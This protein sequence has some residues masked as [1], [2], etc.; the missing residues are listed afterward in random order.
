MSGRYVR[1]ALIVVVVLA[2]AATGA[3]AQSVDWVKQAGGRDIDQ[4]RGVGVDAA[5]NVYVTGVFGKSLACFFCGLPATFGPGSPNET[6]LTP[7]DGTQ[8]LFVAKYDNAGVLQWAKSAGSGGVDDAYGIAV[9]HEGNSYVTCT[10]GGAF[11]HKYDTNGNLVWAASLNPSGL[12]FAVGVGPDGSAVAA[13]YA[14]DPI[15][16]G[17]IVPVWR[18][19][20]EGNLLWQR[21][22]TGLCFG[23]GTGVSID[24]EG[25]SRVAGMFFAGFATFGPGE[26]NETTLSDVNGAGNEMFV[27]SY[28]TA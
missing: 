1:L 17:S 25:G 3:V 11:V 27:A 10:I 21:Q 6:V 5:G 28:D 19:G 26:P 7:V 24:A 14:A 15:G 23:G 20:P 22:A 16:G 12:A 9:D 13:G 4:A 18:V 2:L 8:D